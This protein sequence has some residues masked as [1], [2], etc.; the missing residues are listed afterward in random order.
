MKGCKVAINIVPETSTMH[1]TRLFHVNSK[2]HDAI[3]TASKTTYRLKNVARL[4][5]GLTH[6]EQLERVD[7]SPHWEQTKT[8]QRETKREKTYTDQDF[9]TAFF[10]K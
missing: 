8:S 2:D 7:Y 5:I 1:T 4:E 9:K 3:Y 10:L 6:L